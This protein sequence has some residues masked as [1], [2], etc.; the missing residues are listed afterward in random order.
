MYILYAT[1]KLI[2]MFRNNKYI[3]RKDFL[4]CN[5]FFATFFNIPPSLFI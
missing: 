1:R 4:H 2:N 3:H 5:T